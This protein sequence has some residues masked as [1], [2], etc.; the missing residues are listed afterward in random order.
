MCNI[1]THQIQILTTFHM[2][3]VTDLS[4]IDILHQNY[5]GIL[6]EWVKLCEEKLS[7]RKMSISAPV[8]QCH[9]KSEM[10]MTFWCIG[11]CNDET[12]LKTECSQV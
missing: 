2:F 8:Y 11:C 6:V 9:E 3:A 5:L 7:L 12:A 10:R 1:H 4:R